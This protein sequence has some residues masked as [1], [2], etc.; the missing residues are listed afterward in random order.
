MWY[1]HYL[2]LIIKGKVMSSALLDIFFF[3]VF[4]IDKYIRIKKWSFA[5]EKKNYLKILIKY[6]ALCF[7]QESVCTIVY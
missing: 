1:L 5:R 3:L 4:I 7:A 2:L 6:I